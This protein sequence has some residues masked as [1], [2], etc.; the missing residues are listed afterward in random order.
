VCADLRI[1]HHLARSGRRRLRIERAQCFVRLLRRIGVDACRR[2]NP[3]GNAA[4]RHSAPRAAAASARIRRR[5]VGVSDALGR[6]AVA[7]ELRF[8]PIDRRTI[9]IAALPPIAELSEALDGRLVFLEI[10]SADE[11]LHRV[12]GLR[13][14]RR[15]HD[16]SDKNRRN[17]ARND[18]A[19][20]SSDEARFYQRTDRRPVRGLLA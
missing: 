18:P 19:H 15:E 12:L 6:T 7:L 11:R 5:I 20:L 3:S 2:P 14:L 9:A 10:E 1:E 13:L 17:Q 16:T 8:D 4:A